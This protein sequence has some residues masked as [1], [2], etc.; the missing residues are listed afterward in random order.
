MEPSLKGLE[1]LMSLCRELGLPL[2]QGP[3]ATEDWTSREL[4]PGQPV[5]PLLAS[6]FLRVGEIGRASCRERVL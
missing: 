4:F 2:R 5:D 3:P 6:V 1:R